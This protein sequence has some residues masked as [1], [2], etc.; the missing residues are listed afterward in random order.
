MPGGSRVYRFG[1]FELDAPRARLFRGQTRVP[2]PDSQF[3]ILLRL[4][5]HVGE[6]V[7]KDALA[8]A[9]WRR[10]SITRVSARMPEG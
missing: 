10:W 4:V 9:A 2:L 5:S 6:V 3:A 7:S 1:P 8:D